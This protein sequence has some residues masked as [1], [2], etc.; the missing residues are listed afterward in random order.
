MVVPPLSADTQAR[1]RAFLPAAA[2]VTNPVDMIASATATQFER[3][4]AEVGADQD[5]DSVL[6]IFI[7]PLVTD[8]TDVAKAIHTAAS[9]LGKPVIASFMGAQGVLP[10]LAPVPSFPFPESAAVA[11]AAVARYGEW[12][13]EPLPRGAS[14]DEALRLEVR[15]HV[16]R[17]L[18]R[19]GGWLAAGERGALLRA[20]RIP[21]P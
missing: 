11:L 6:A 7:P 4:I 19:G 13:R 17:A 8:P 9:G 18:E 14:M 3:A 2:S 15:T 16:E 20:A 21:P 12:L 5:V 10:D 1:L